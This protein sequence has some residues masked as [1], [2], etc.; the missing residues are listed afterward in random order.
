MVSKADPIKYILSRPIL[1][2]R[3]VKW[4]MI[5]K[6]HDLVS[7]PQKAVKGRAL[8]DFLADHPIPDE[9]E[10]NDDLPGEGVFFVDVLPPWEMYFDGAATSDGAGAG[11]VFIS[12]ERHVLTYAFVLTQL[13][14]NNMAEYQAL[15]LGL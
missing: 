1:S 14:S 13:C 5:L 15:I 2:G 4:A 8:A 10:L 9:W 11:V 6:Q 7:V 12:P 3:L